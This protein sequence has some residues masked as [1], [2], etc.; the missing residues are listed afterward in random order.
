M[1]VVILLTSNLSA[2][3]FARFMVGSLLNIIKGSWVKNYLDRKETY[4][5]SQLICYEK[6]KRHS[7]HK[8]PQSIGKSPL[9]YRPKSV[10]K[11]GKN[12]VF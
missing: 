1:L 12:N 6:V 10:L 7:S 8:P 2:T 4:L 3:S 5:F 9:L 11:I